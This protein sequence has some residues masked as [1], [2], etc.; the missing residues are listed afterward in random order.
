[1]EESLRRLKTD[2][3]DIF[4]HHNIS[5]RDKMDK[6]MGPRGAFEGMS[7]AI[8]QGKVRFPGFTSHILSMT[9]AMIKTDLFDT[10]QI[11]FNF[12]DHQALEAVFRY[13]TQFRDI[14]PD[15]GIERIDE[16]REI[17]GVVNVEGGLTEEENRSIAECRRV[18]GVTWCHRY[19]Y[20]QP[21]PEGI[22]T[23][24]VLAAKSFA[25]RMP[26]DAAVSF[27]D[28]PFRKAE[29]CIECRTCVKRRPYGLEIPTLLKNQ[30]K[31]WGHYLRERARN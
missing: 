20:C 27:V 22:P 9:A 8:R 2:H 5:S 17:L 13:L 23:S 3:V 11:P 10:V 16:L 28:E 31:A 24:M 26:F 12:L 30:R 14:V 19:D 21:C 1:M 6:V 15:P 18:L 7:Q 4:Q 25:R 29:N